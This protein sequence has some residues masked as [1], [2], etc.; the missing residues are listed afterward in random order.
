MRR[1][2]RKKPVRVQFATIP[3]TTI[4]ERGTSTAAVAAKAADDGRP[5]RAARPARAR[6]VRDRDAVARARDPHAGGGEHPLG[7]VAARPRLDDRG[8]PGREQAGQQHA[9]LDWA[10][11]PAAAYSIPRSAPPATANGG[12]RPSVASIRA[13]MRTSGSAIR[14]TGRRR[15]DASPS[16]VHRPPSCP[17][18]QPGSSRISVP[19]LPTSIVPAARAAARSPTPCTTMESARR[20][21]RAPSACTAASVELVSAAAR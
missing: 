8:R 13:P 2:I 20:S 11:A 16:S 10:D 19:A 4:R 12:K 3:S 1:R 18:S 21:T 17:A 15:I 5:A 6:P 14:S 9:R 7:V